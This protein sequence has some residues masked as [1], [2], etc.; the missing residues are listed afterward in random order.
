MSANKARV[1]SFLLAAADQMIDGARRF[2]MLGILV[3]VGTDAVRPIDGT[4]TSPKIWP[5]NTPPDGII[6]RVEFGC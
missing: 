3:T 5:K 6:W 1:G 2:S 4:G